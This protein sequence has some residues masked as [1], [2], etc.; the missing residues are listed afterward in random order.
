M[1]EVTGINEISQDKYNH[2]TIIMAESFVFSVVII[3]L[4][5]SFIQTQHLGKK[6]RF[7]E[8][9]Q[10]CLTIFLGDLL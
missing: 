5:F 6:I 10:T 3:I 9:I 8:I 2:N 1:C 4:I 7:R